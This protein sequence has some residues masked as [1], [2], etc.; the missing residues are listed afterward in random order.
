MTD[1]QQQLLQDMKSFDSSVLES[2]QDQQYA[3]ELDSQYEELEIE[4]VLSSYNPS[5]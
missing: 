2:K 5:I 4:R 1:F 3:D